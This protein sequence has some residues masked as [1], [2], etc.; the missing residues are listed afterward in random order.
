MPSHRHLL[1]F[2]MAAALAP[3]AAGLVSPTANAQD[4]SG[5]GWFWY[6]SPPP[7]PKLKPQPLPRPVAPTAPVVSHKPSSPPPLSV[8]WIKQNRRKYMEKAI[9]NPTAANV[10]TFMYINKAMFDRA[11]NFANMFAYQA[12]FKTAL[13]PSFS[14]PTTQAGIDAFY[15]RL[16]ASQQLSFQWLEHRTGIFFFFTSECPYCNLQYQQLQYFLDDFPAYKKHVYYVSMDGKPLPGMT[17]VKIYKNTGQ[18][19]FFKLVET[20]ALVLAAPPKTFIVISQG[21]AITA[22][23]KKQL[24]LAASHYNLLPQNVENAIN[25][26]ARGQLGTSQMNAAANAKMTTPKEIRGYLHN[27]I[28]N[29]LNNWHKG[30]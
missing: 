26:Y 18:A 13:N 11:Q 22:V 27:G 16:Y 30:S 3:A 19:K 9:N 14:E 28:M 4:Y 21:E 10:D 7:P 15:S 1:H 8:Q 23:I 20:P 24:L 25:P 2:F 17:G 5:H 29:R 6:Q 12:K